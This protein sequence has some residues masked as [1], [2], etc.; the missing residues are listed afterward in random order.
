MST[1][2]VPSNAIFFS[3]VM[4]FNHNGVTVDTIEDG[5]VL[6]TDGTNFL[7]AYP[8]ADIETYK[9]DNNNSQYIYSN[10]YEG[11][12]FTRY[13]GNN[14]DRIIEAIQDFFSVRLISEYEDEYADIVSPKKGHT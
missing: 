13:G 12:M 14:P 6:L 9:I 3:E 2:Y 11:V 5:N 1:D 7:W 8:R 4:T 10:P